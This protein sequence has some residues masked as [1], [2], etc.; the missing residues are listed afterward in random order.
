MILSDY[1]EIR[2]VYIEKS[3]LKTSTHVQKLVNKRLIEVI[4]TFVDCEVYF[5]TQTYFSW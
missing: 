4:L 2:E 5:L 1:Q 3:G